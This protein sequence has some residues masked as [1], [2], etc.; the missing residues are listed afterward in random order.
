M[1]GASCE[2]TRAN[3]SVSQLRPR[4]D[5]RAVC[6]QQRGAPLRLAIL[7]RPR[8]APR[9]FRLRRLHRR[10]ES[11]LARRTQRR[12]RRWYFPRGG[13]GTKRGTA[14]QES[15]GKSFQSRDVARPPPP[16][17]TS[18][19]VPVADGCNRFLM[20]RN[21]S[22]NCL[23]PP[24]TVLATGIFHRSNE[25]FLAFCGAGNTGANRSY[26]CGDVEF[27]I[28]P[29]SFRLCSCSCFLGGSRM[30][31]IELLFGMLR[32]VNFYIAL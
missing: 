31:S 2:E 8:P 12:C 16:A 14:G 5:P 32:N 13:H 15:R 11:N 27:G 26:N 1:S 9:P 17:A 19:A 7:P 23:D 18:L 24:S 30:F 6:L 28:L 3:N 22:W 29:E 20:R 25:N 21:V 4:H 10:R